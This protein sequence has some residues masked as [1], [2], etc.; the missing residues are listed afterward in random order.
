MKEINKI[1]GYKKG[2]CKYSAEEI[3]KYLVNIYQN[4]Y[5]CLGLI[6]GTL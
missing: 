4:K 2:K 1:I 3:I 5:N 6:S